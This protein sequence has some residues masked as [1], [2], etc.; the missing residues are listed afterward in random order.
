MFY[1][2]ASDVQHKREFFYLKVFEGPSVM[3]SRILKLNVNSDFGGDSNPLAA[4]R[5]TLP[6]ET[7]R[8]FDSADSSGCSDVTWR[9]ENWRKSEGYR[10]YLHLEPFQVLPN[11]PLR[12]G[13][14]ALQHLFL[15][16]FLFPTNLLTFRFPATA[17]SVVAAA[18]PSLLCSWKRIRSPKSEFA[19]IIHI[20][21]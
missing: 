10:M 12:H 9:L 15:S 7:D 20:L 11:K 19:G 4:G 6:A 8:Q 2:S 3:L 1:F 5:Y 16:A 14:C 17:I 21:L 13:A 18:S